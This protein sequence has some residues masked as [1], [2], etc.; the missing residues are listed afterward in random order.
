MWTGVP[1]ADYTTR[2]DHIF[3]LIPRARVILKVHLQIIICIHSPIFVP[4]PKIIVLHQ[5]VETR[6]ENIEVVGS[7]TWLVKLIIFLK[8]LKPRSRVT[9]LY[10][11][12]VKEPGG[13]HRSFVLYPW[14]IT[15]RN[16][17]SFRCVALIGNR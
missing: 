5:L 14:T 1:R 7:I 11:E 15:H 17:P 3:H 8:R 9:V 2:W 10:T 6:L 12:H 13:A 16:L 4:M